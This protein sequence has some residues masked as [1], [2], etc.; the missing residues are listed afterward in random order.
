MRTLKSAAAFNENVTGFWITAMDQTQ[1]FCL[2]GRRGSSF[3]SP[4]CPGRLRASFTCLFN[5]YRRNLTPDGKTVGAFCAALQARGTQFYH[6]AGRVQSAE[7][8]DTGWIVEELEFD[9]G[10]ERI[11][12]LFS[13]AS[14]RLWGPPRLLYNGQREPFQWGT[15]TRTWSLPLSTM[16]CGHR[17]RWSNISVPRRGA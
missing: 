11:L 8:W 13:L 14:S 3:S 16:Y 17:E 1:D 7:R 12:F 4:L 2:W 6:R 15:A 9:S 10:Q 5:R